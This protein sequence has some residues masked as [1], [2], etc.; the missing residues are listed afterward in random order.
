M[1]T[2]GRSISASDRRE[3][4]SAILAA[5]SV[6]YLDV[7]FVSGVVADHARRMST[8]ELHDVTLEVLSDLV[9]AGRLRAGDLEPPGEFVPWPETP[10]VAAARIRE[11]LRALTGDLGPGDVAWFEVR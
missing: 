1:T 10:A 4:E 3:I 9:Q 6:D 5:G 7:W 2:S 8:D 11:G